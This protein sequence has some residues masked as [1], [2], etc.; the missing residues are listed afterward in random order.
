[1]SVPYRNIA[2]LTLRFQSHSHQALAQFK[3]SRYLAELKST[4]DNQVLEQ[5]Q[6][7]RSLNSHARRHRR[8]S[9]TLFA[10][11]HV[12]WKSAHDPSS[13]DN[14]RKRVRRRVRADL[15]YCARTW[16]QIRYRTRGANIPSNRCDIA[17]LSASKPSRH[18]QDRSHTATCIFEPSIQRFLGYKTKVPTRGMT[19]KPSNEVSQQ[20]VFTGWKQLTKPDREVCVNCLWMPVHPTHAY[21]TVLQIFGANGGKLMLNLQPQP[22]KAPLASGETHVHAIPQKL[23][24]MW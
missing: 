11:Q 24:E 20:I 2:V 6:H 9:R 21:D 7:A 3:P 22:T 15:V 19:C 1:M 13:T 8:T 10:A 14:A 18:L 17:N 4:S 23:H 16:I 5:Q 12:K